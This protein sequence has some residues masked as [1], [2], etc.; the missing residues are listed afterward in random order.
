[1]EGA[2]VGGGIG[3][4]GLDG[5]GDA[6]FSLPDF[7]LAYLDGLQRTGVNFPGKGA[8]GLIA[9]LFHALQDTLDAFQHHRIVG[10]GTA[11]QGFPGI[12][13]GVL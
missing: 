9:L 10:G 7:G 3:Y 6:L 4:G 1:M 8:E 2:D 12:P 5:G 11:A 13:G